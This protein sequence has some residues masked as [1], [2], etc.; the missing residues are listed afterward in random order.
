MRELLKLDDDYLRRFGE[1]KKRKA[2]I[3]EL[4]R[5]KKENLHK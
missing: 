5:G 1:E 2:R 3:V 4:E